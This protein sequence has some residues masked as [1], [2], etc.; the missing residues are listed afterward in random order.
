M[1]REMRS[2][3]SAG[4]GGEAM[5]LNPVPEAG[6]VRAS[7][8]G[9]DLPPL[10]QE[11]HA[12]R[13]DAVQASG[14]HPAF[15]AALDRA[16]VKIDPACVAGIVYAARLRAERRYTVRASDRAPE[17]G[18]ASR[19]LSRIDAAIDALTAFDAERGTPTG[20]SQTAALAAY[21][22]QLP[23]AAPLDLEPVFGALRAERARLAADIGLLDGRSR[24]ASR[25]RL[26]AEALA[27][28][29]AALTDGRIGHRTGF[30]DFVRVCCELVTEIAP[31][32]TLLRSAVT[33]LRK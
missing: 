7:R 6:Q 25:L 14:P 5:A 21:L 24:P 30:T 17:L 11:R 15:I 4:R 22:G 23:D 27:P 31:D 3:R 19:A 18:R 29:Y 12:A 28:F 13:W 16:R 20:A 32:E 26:F 8:A 10:D 33:K 1:T 2:M 9:P